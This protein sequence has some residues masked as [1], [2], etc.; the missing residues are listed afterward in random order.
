M[1]I[2][3][4]Y[5]KNWLDENYVIIDTRSPKEYADDHII[6]SI[7]LPVLYDQE[8]KLV[9]RTFK[10]KSTFEA[11]QLGAQMVMKNISNHLKCSLKNFDE[12]KKLIFY[13]KRGGNRSNS[14]YTV[15]EKIG[16]KCSV[17]SGGYKSY[18]KFVIERTEKLSLSREF[19]IISGRTG[20]G[21]TRILNLLELNGLQVLDLE[22]LACHR[23][24]ILG[25]LI[26]TPQPTQKQFESYIFETLRKFQSSEIIFVESESRKI[27]KLTIPEKFFSSIYNSKL[28]KIE[29]YLNHRVDFLIKEYPNFMEDHGAIFNL[30]NFL[31]KRISKENILDIEKY[32]ANRDFKKLASDLLSLHYDKSYDNS[33]LKR[34]GE[35]VKQFN[36]N[37]GVEDA[38]DCVCRY[39]IDKNLHKRDSL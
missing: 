7:N 8:Y 34:K 33:L 5:K 4:L 13:C 1:K 37:C 6:G 22:G 36:F 14:F 20:N 15:C 24:S 32:I 17:I 11:K 16:W 12:K 30:V 3:E 9:G 26:D 31:R 23:G 10:E 19:I 39:V 25:S 38:V 27:G 28:I 18:R 21:K 2:S 29:N 35:L